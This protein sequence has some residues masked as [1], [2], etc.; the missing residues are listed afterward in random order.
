MDPPESSV[1]GFAEAWLREQNRFWE[2]WARDA[3]AADLAAAEAAWSQAC[4]RWWEQV[5][6]LVPA[7]LGSQLQAALQQT[8][9]FLTLATGHAREQGAGAQTLVDPTIMFRAALD[10][11]DRGAQPAPEDDVH[12]RYLRAYQ[13]LV[14][15]L[16]D[17]AQ[18]ALGR[19]KERLRDEDT[20]SLETT[21]TVYAEEIEARYRERAGRDAFAR[22]IGEL[23]NAQVQVL[24]AKGEAPR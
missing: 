1:P 5:E 22:L 15:E 11:I 19:V 18:E 14:G 2:S 20:G 13:A 16:A 17:I 8:R 21:Y 24:A 3:D 6:Q 4:D 10:A 23:V 12:A 9:L 7:P